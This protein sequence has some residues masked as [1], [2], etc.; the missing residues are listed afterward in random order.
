MQNI[1]IAIKNAL[2]EENFYFKIG[3]Y[4]LAAVIFS[5]TVVVK[6]SPLFHSSKRVRIYSE[7]IKII[8]SPLIA[9]ISIAIAFGV[10]QNSIFDLIHLFNLKGL[11]ILYAY[12]LLIMFL[13]LMFLYLIIGLT[14]PDKKNVIYSDYT[15]GSNINSELSKEQRKLEKLTINKFLTSR[16]PNKHLKP[17]LKRFSA[18]RNNIK[19]YEFLRATK[20]HLFIHRFIIVLGSY[21]VGLLG[22]FLFKLPFKF[23]SLVIIS[24]III[25]LIAIVNTLY[26][27]N[28]SM[29]N[30]DHLKNY[31]E[32]S[33]EDDKE[34]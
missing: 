33:D 17:L 8:S 2:N 29:K 20:T 19:D 15:K 1:D 28:I 31:R 16:Y 26:I 4:I 22:Y 11:S 24:F 14:N 23:E 13:V 5:I 6:V 7:R 12:I 9:T 34:G 10:L 3:W 18:S 25:L 32:K 27:L 21:Y 30:Y